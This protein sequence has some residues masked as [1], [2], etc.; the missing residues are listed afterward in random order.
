VTITTTEAYPRV[1]MPTSRSTSAC[2][3]GMSAAGFAPVAHAVDGLRKARID[4]RNG[5]QG[6]TR[7]WS[8]PV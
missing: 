6:G 4:V 7:A 8:P 1:L 3:N 2:R 5:A